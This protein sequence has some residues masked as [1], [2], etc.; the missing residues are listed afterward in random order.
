LIPGACAIAGCAVG[1]GRSFPD[2]GDLFR[3]IAAFPLTATSLYQIKIQ[4][5]RHCLTLFFGN[6]WHIFPLEIC[7]NN[8]NSPH[9]RVA[10]INSFLGRRTQKINTGR[11][12][13]APH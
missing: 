5:G 1:F 3:A 4:L 2:T 9:W 12:T 10:K 6:H 8:E 7:G 11:L 13:P